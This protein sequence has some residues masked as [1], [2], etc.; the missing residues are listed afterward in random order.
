LEA[1]AQDEYG[2]PAGHDTSPEGPTKPK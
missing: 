1:E 2:E